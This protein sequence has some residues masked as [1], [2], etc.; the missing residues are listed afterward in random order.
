[1]RRLLPLLV[2]VV[3]VVAFLLVIRVLL[4]PMHTAIKELQAQNFD[5]KLQVESAKLVTEEVGYLLRLEEEL[6]KTPAKEKLGDAIPKVA[7]KLIDLQ[8]RYAD[9]RLPMSLILGLIEIE[10]GFDPKATSTFTKDGKTYPLAYG[11]MQVTQPT[12]IPYLKLLDQSWSAE[13]V[14]QPELNLELGV[15]I[16]VNE[17]RTWVQKG[18]EDPD[19]YHLSIDSYFWGSKWVAESLSGKSSDRTGFASRSYW[20]RVRQAQMRWRDKGF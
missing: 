15:M 5:L 4:T 2:F 16:L 14:Y 3:C 12:A 8:K 17:H 18:L 6:L 19:D 10:S 11:L 1:M 20:A 13:T 7:Y 9:D